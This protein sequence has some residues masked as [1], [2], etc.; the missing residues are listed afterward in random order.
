MGSNDELQRFQTLQ[1]AVRS[2]SDGGSPLEKLAAG[3][4]TNDEIAALHA[5]AERSDQGKLDLELYR[6]L[7]ADEKERIQARV[8][9]RVRTEA[10]R[11]WKLRLAAGGAAVAMLAALAPL[12]VHTRV[13]V[14]WGSS[15]G[16]RPEPVLR[17]DVPGAS[18]R[19]PIVPVHGFEGQLEVRGTAFVQD[20]RAILWEPHASSEGSLINLSGTREELFP[21]LKGEGRI[22]VAV[23]VPGPRLTPGELVGHEGRSWTGRYQVLGKPVFLGD[24]PVPRKDG[25]PCPP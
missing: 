16:P 6:P 17:L 3:E 1:A 14:A 7:G 22:L 19:L 9:D 24:Q 21:C 11:R 18:V 20:G 25:T 2:R 13:E 15:L 23:G 12:Y 10:S 5:E 4:L 8:R